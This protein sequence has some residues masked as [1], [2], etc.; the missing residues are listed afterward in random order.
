M[1]N[2][3]ALQSQDPN[4]ATQTQGTELM[5]PKQVEQPM[6]ASAQS[7]SPATDPRRLAEPQDQATSALAEPAPLIQ[8]VS[9]ANLRLSQSFEASLDDTDELVRYEVR[10]PKPTDFFR[11]CAEAGWPFTTY[12]V[13]MKNEGGLYI[14]TP[15]AAE[16]VPDHLETA[17]FY[18]AVNMQGVYFVVPFTAK[19][20]QSLQN[21]WKSTMRKALARAQTDWV[22]MIANQTGG[23]Y[24]CNVARAT[25]PPVPTWPAVS[26]DEVMTTA[27]E[28]RVI[29]S[30]NHPVI[31]RLL[32]LA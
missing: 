8:G 31:E 1:P 15:E 16:L 32:G 11:I 29:D 6:P 27:M 14:V 17:S 4:H 12:V 25:N 21:P 13:D 10:K 9:L 23:H 26:A 18:L 2:Q 20:A 30:P 22:Q 5:Q 28:G 7:T 3:R 19:N 24:R